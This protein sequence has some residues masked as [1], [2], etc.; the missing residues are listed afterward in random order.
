M[1]EIL[2]ATVVAALTAGAVEAS[3]DSASQAVKDAYSGLK[4][5]VSRRFKGKNSAE[6]ALAE[7]EHDPETW[8]MPLTKAVSEHAADDEIVALARQMLE[9][10]EDQ[11]NSG[12]KYSINIGNAQGT[13]IGDNS[14]VTQ[15]FN[16]PKQTRTDQ[17]GQG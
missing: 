8:A 6:V 15:T 12:S 16:D 11:Q 4:A 7:A 17:S 1:A 13:V 10:L 9:L 2:V 5:L 3:K 14:Q